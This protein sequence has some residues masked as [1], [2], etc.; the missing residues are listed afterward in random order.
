MYHN[1]P[2]YLC[3]LQLLRVLEFYSPM[4]Q[5]CLLPHWCQH[6]LWSNCD[7]PFVTPFYSQQWSIASESSFCFLYF[8]S[9]HCFWQ[10]H[11]IL[12]HCTTGICGMEEK[13]LIKFWTCIK[14]VHVYAMPFVQKVYWIQKA[15]NKFYCCCTAW[16]Q[17]L[18]SLHTSCLVLSSVNIKCT[19]V[20]T[21]CLTYLKQ[22]YVELCWFVGIT[23]TKPH[24][25]FKRTTGLIKWK[26]TSRSIT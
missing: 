19:Y 2:F 25:P 12:A 23:N 15:H 18:C 17:N 3:N 20:P 11:P 16:I 10:A 22:F 5:F 9:D 24:S 26:G 8:C 4:H 21:F 1:L 13:F 7:C 6:V 14:V